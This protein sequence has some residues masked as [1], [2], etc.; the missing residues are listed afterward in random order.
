MEQ[1][2]ADGM[3]NV[4]RGV[5]VS[6]TRKQRIRGSDSNTPL[7]RTGPHVSLITLGGS[8]TIHPCAS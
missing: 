8:L 3:T 4:D 7:H 6:P 1:L 2:A 5:G